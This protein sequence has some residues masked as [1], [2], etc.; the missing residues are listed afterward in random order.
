[1]KGIIIGQADFRYL[2]RDNWD[3]L[4]QSYNPICP[5]DFVYFDP[6]Y[7]TSFTD[8][9]ADGFNME[10]LAKVRQVM[11]ELTSIGTFTMLSMKDIL[12]VREMFQD[13][14]IVSI[15][16]NCRVN[17]DASKRKNGMSE[18]IIINYDLKTF[19]IL[20]GISAENHKEKEQ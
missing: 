10:D 16:T 8:Y 13:Y 9:T 2:M 17:P 4:D 11:D 12:E 18:L 1:M 3:Y 19:E 7:P 14:L 15:K 20:D 6:P 5:T